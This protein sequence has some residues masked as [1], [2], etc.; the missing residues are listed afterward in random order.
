MIFRVRTDFCSFSFFFFRARCTR[1][2]YIVVPI[3]IALTRTVAEIRVLFANDL[4]I[5]STISLFVRSELAWLGFFFPNSRPS[6][7][8]VDSA[9]DYFY[10]QLRPTLEL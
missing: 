7:S 3:S 10:Q 9:G 1:Y 6:R 4:N 5:P 2:V 8:R